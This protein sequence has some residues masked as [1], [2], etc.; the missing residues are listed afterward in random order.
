MSRLHSGYSC[1]ISVDREAAQ[2]AHD[3]E[4]VRVHGVDVKQ[5]VLHLPDDAAEG[6]QIAP[7]HV[8]AVHASQRVG[9]PAAVAEHADESGRD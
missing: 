8:V 3:H 4:D 7:E 6:R 9:E 2:V 5:V 1:D